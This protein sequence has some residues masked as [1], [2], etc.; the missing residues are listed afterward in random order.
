MPDVHAA[1]MRAVWIRIADALDDGH[2]ALVIQGLE[3]REVRIQADGVRQ[4]EHLVRGEAEGRPDGCVAR[5]SKRDERVDAVIAARK[6]QHD[7]DQVVRGAWLTVNRGGGPCNEGRREE[8]GGHEQ[9]A[10]AEK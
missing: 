6:L 3:F 4:L 10:A 2:L 1:E 7:E 5:I 8:A 9:R